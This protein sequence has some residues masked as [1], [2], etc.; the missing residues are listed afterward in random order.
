[1]CQI[2]FVMHKTIKIEKY[3]V[4]CQENVSI[5]FEKKYVCLFVCMYELYVCVFVCTVCMYAWL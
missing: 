5:Y 3:A 1:M 2:F 4:V